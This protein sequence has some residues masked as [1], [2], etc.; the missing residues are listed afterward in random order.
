MNRFLEVLIGIVLG[1]VVVLGAYFTIGSIEG[2]KYSGTLLLE[3]Q[4]FTEFKYELVREDV[5][6][7]SLDVVGA[8]SPY[9]VSFVVCT[10]EDFSFGESSGTT[11]NKELIALCIGVSVFLVAI[12]LGMDLFKKGT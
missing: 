1:L 12:F 7:V 11:S 9:L 6:I 2:D 4:E 5:K 10:K 8:S 3:T